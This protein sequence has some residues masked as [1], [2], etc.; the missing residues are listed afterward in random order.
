MFVF[1][2]EK[3][4]G[5]G[6]GHRGQVLRPRMSVVCDGLIFSVKLNGKWSKRRGWRGRRISFDVL[7]VQ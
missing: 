2:S 3:I 7:L 1:V 4:S 5:L 6:C